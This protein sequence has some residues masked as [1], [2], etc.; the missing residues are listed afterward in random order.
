MIVVKSRAEI[1]K[2]RRASRIV[3][4][5]L[6]AVAAAVRPG[7]TTGE[8]DAIAERII[9]DAGAV[10]SF[11]GYSPDPKR[12][13]PFPATIC[14]SLNDELVH[15]IPGRRSLVCGDVIGVVVG[16]IAD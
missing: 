5:T 14:S 11:K 15:G 10:P 6:E 16:S 4:D 8:L 7:V 12:Q 9:R 2:M 1:E 13:P 3:A